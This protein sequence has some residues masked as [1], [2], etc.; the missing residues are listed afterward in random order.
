[1]KALIYLGK[2]YS[3][4]LALLLF[5]LT[6]LVNRELVKPYVF[7]TNQDATW[8]LNDEMLTKFHLGF[9]R[10]E[11]S[12][13]WVSTI[14][15]SDIDHYKK[16]DLNSWMFR[17]FNSISNLDPKF[18]ENY[19]FGGVY[20]SIIKDDIEGAGII[21]NKGLK[22]FPHDYRLLKDASFHFFYES[23][24]YHRAFELTQT[25][26][27]LY[28]EKK[29][30]IWMI[31]KLEAENG[32]LTDA[33]ASLDLYQK[34]YPI[35]TMIGDKIFQ[36]RYSIKAEI[37]LSCLNLDEKKHCSLY[38]LNRIPYMKTSKGYEAQSEWKPYRRKSISE[39]KSKK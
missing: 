8:N 7:I 13:L 30:F 23:K 3:V 27:K 12:F 2:Y 6:F 24:D 19:S 28:P 34:D 22:L 29:Y 21:F 26:K 37:D 33:L 5:S 39:I 4:A 1:M 10:L 15:E 14:I 32:K 36:N 11:S 35:G 16:K 9:K 25:I 20:L 38:D 18:H 31:T 17:R